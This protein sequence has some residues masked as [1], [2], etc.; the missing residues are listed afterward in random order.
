MLYG[1]LAYGGSTACILGMSVVEKREMCE[2]ARTNLFLAI[3]A[4][5]ASRLI[6]D[7]LSLPIRPC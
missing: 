6:R 7:G 1:A 2:K 3:L 4:V 5:R